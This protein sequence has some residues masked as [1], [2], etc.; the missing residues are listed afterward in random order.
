MGCFYK[1]DFFSPQSERQCKNTPFYI[2]LCLFY[3]FPL[4]VPWDLITYL[5]L[6]TLNKGRI[7]RN[8][9]RKKF[10]KGNFHLLSVFGKKV[11]VNG[12]KGI[13]R[14]CTIVMSVGMRRKVIADA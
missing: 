3:V 6:C 9:C 4:P 1:S 10:L 12:W 8:I 2:T 13:I 14:T 7:L 11:I 5:D